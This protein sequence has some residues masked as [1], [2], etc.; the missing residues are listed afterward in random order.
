MDRL[1]RVVGREG[2]MTERVSLGPDIAGQWLTGVDAINALI[3]DL[4]QPTTEVANVISAVANGDL[5]KK[6]GVDAK[7]EVLR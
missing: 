2:R 1:E 5:S 7:G 6:V 4:V 3:G